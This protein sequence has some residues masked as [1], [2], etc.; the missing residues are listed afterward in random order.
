MENKKQ[1]MFSVKSIKYVKLF[2]FSTLIF[3]QISQ[4]HNKVVVIPILGED[5]P[6]I[7]HPIADSITNTI[8]M[9]FNRL[10]SGSF[11]M[12]SPADEPGRA[13]NGD[14]AEV[15]HTVILTNVFRMQTTEV[16]NA[17]WNKV[18]VESA[19]G[20]NPTQNNTG[21]Y[22]PVES[23]NWFDAVFFAN[24]LSIMEGRIACYSLSGISG[25]PGDG[26]SLFITSVTEVSNCTGY[27]LPSEAEWEYAARAGTTTAYANP[28]GFD[29]ADTETNDG[30][31]ANLH[32][33][34]WYA[35]NREMENADEISAYGDG[36]KP[37]AKKQANA[38]G[39]YDMHGNLFELTGDWFAAYSGDATNP[40]GPLTGTNRVVRGGCWYGGAQ[41]S[42]SA[43]RFNAPPQNTADDL[44]FRLVLVD[45]E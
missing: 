16:T 3:S 31:N 12:G 45:A 15:Q 42:R 30:F 25:I 35:F 10:P 40:T 9:Q 4:A 11:V 29:D 17:Q 33:M 22:F 28:I 32:A 6:A 34:G 27:R 39:I 7:S 38:W 1:S 37:V 5:I 20:I 14:N 23:I 21:D 8:G 13:S 41:V 43:L 44:G 19:L 2:V 18:I 36:A 26:A 24:T